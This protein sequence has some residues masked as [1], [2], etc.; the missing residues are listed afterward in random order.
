[1]SKWTNHRERWKNCT[2]CEL[3]ESCTQ[4]VLARGRLPCDILFV[5]EAPG[6]SEDVLGKPF[7]GPAGKLLDKITRSGLSVASFPVSCAWTNL[8]SCIPKDE[9]GAKT[10]EPPPESIEACAPRLREFVRLADP[11]VLVAVGLVAERWL[12]KILR[13]RYRI[14]NVMH[15]AAILRMDV[16]Q[17]GLAIQRTVDRI[18]DVVT[19]LGEKE[20]AYA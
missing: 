4:V 13:A 8:V 18:E 5:G 11:Q 20:Q 6:V 15:P 12:H 1:M 7:V 9:E 2:E 14:V 16:S 3:S 19:S 17:R 10:R